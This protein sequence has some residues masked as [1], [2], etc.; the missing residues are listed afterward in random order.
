M[1]KTFL[2]LAAFGLMLAGCMHPS[3]NPLASTNYPACDD[4]RAQWI[5]GARATQLVG[6]EAMEAARAR[7]VRWAYE[8]QPV[9]MDYRPHRLTIVMDL[10]GTVTEIRC[11]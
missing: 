6:E 11:G 8:N 10:E 5:V 2:P 9:T 1:A 4:S 7:E 3:E